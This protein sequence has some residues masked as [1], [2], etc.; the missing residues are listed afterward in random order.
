MRQIV[1]VFL[2][3]SVL[4][5]STGFTLSKHF[6]GENLAHITLNETKTCCD[7]EEDMP[8][9]CCHDEFEQLL[10]DDSQVDHQLLQLQP[11]KF[12]TL[13]VLTHFLSFSPEANVSVSP[14]TAFPSPP[15]PDTAV[16]LRVQSFLI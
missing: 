6:C 2:L 10:L 13:N 12:F 15:L 3:C 11:L 9:D 14:W 7:G 8:S 4:V 1:S 5:S 16:Y